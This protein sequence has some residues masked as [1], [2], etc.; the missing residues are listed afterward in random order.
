MAITDIQN[1]QNTFRNT[2]PINRN[3][4]TNQAMNAFKGIANS[5]FGRVAGGVGRYALGIPAAVASTPFLARSGIN[6]LTER[7]PNATRSS[8]FNIDLTKNANE[9]AALP[10][11]GANAW[12]EMGPIPDGGVVPP[13]TNI[14]RP[15]PSP[16]Q[17]RIMNEDLMR[18]QQNR[19]NID[20]KGFSFNPLDWGVMGLMKRMVEPN[21][22]EENFGRGYFNTDSSGRTYG[23]QAH[24]VFA[25]KNVVSAFGQG[26]GGAAQKRIDTIENTLRTKYN[27]GD[28]EIE[29]VY[30]GTYT[31][32]IKSQLI[33]RLRNFS[34]DLSGYNKALAAGTG[35]ADTTR[36]AVTT[37]NVVTDVRNPNQGDPA[38]RDQGGGYSTRGGFTGTRGSPQGARGT[39][40]PASGR[41]HHSW[42]HGGRI[43]YRNG[44][45]VDEDINIQGPGYDFNENIE[46]ASA[47]DPQDALNDMSL[48]IFGKSLHELNEEEYQM[49]IDMANDQAA[50]GQDQGLASL[51]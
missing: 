18:I 9:G 21:T 3:I 16:Y 2:A 26:M 38:S 44:E 17:D 28:E 10:D 41:G 43:G 11:V 19:G 31:G 5:P 29:D 6:Y 48:Q 14:N 49:L 27:L 7:D 34:T 46:M 47:V 23:N 15:L 25:G 36:G 4:F 33:Q 12:S 39:S 8:L 40:T 24:D 35:G 45:F 37:G 51:V 1:W 22:P 50:S 32:P 20:N 30:A 42:A 13:I